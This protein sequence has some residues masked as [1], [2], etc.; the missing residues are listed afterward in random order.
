MANISPIIIFFLL[1]IFTFPMN[2]QNI[3]LCMKYITKLCL[4][5]FPTICEI[6]HLK[7]YNRLI[8]INSIT[9][10]VLSPIMFTILEHPLFY[11]NSY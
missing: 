5:I 11:S 10:L 9:C 2:E 3:S 4:K 8:L 7:Y 1:C 6:H